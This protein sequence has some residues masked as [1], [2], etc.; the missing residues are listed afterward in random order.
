MSAIPYDM[1]DVLEEIEPIAIGVLIA[2]LVI[3]LLLLVFAIVSYVFSSAGM[4]AIA[5]RRGIHHPG[6]AWVPIANTWILGS[7]S[8]QYQ[9]VAKGKVRSRRKLLLTLNIIIAALPAVM[10]ISSTTAAL[11][12]LDSLG[13]AVATTLAIAGI[14]W[15]ALVVLAI[16]N[17]VFTYIAYYDLYSSCD[18]NNAVAF[19]VLSIFISATQPFFVF[20]CRKKDRGM[21]PRKETQPPVQE[22]PQPE[23]IVEPEIAV[24]EPCTAEET[25]FADEPTE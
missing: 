15:F 5:K 24:A 13:S 10:S 25:D 20:A 16:V 21:P 19:L 8:D 7:I 2:V 11:M 9:F 22:I 17:A 23:A 12:S 14:I 1:L 4:Y 3:Y 18:P 6:L